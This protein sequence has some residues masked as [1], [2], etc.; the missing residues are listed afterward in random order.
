MEFCMQ[1]VQ[2]ILARGGQKF[3]WGGTQNLFDGGGQAL[4]GRYYP[5]MGEGVPPILPILASPG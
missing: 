1:T 5:L 3:S 4:I 2:K